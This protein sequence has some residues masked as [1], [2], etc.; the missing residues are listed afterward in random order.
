MRSG[1]FAGRK[2]ARG[3]LHRER[4]TQKP[5]V[6]VFAQPNLPVARS[7]RFDNQANPRAAW[8]SETQSE[9]TNAKASLPLDGAFAR[10]PRGADK[11]DGTSAR[12]EKLMEM[13]AAP[14]IFPSSYN[15]ERN[16]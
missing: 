5:V 4:L 11:T 9:H 1:G 3:L 10:L 8:I 7:D 15:L 13:T 16:G 6:P 2:N 12:K 14:W